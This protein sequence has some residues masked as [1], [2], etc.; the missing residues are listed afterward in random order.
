M[1]SVTLKPCNL[2][3][4]LDSYE[5]NSID[6][7][8]MCGVGRRLPVEAV[9]SPPSITNA[10]PSSS[11]VVR[12]GLYRFSN[13]TS[14]VVLVVSSDD[15]C[16]LAARF[17]C[18]R[19]VHYL[20]WSGESVKFYVAADDFSCH[21]L[22]SYDSD[23]ER[24]RALNQHC[25]DMMLAYFNS[26]P[27]LGF[28]ATPVALIYTNC[29]SESSRLKFCKMFPLDRSFLMRF[30]YFDEDWN[31]GEKV[32]RPNFTTVS[33][34]RQTLRSYRSCGSIICSIATSF[35]NNMMPAL[36][37][38]YTREPL[39]GK[40]D[41]SLLSFPPIFFTR[42][43]Q[44]EY[45]LEDRLGGD[46]DLTEPG[47][48]DAFDI[49]QFFK[50]QVASNS[51]LFAG[52]SEEW[53]RCFGFEVCCSQLRRTQ[54][55]AQPTADT[56]CSGKVRRL[57]C[58]NEIHA[59]ICEDMTNDEVKHFYPLIQSFR[60]MDKIGF[61]YP[62]GES[63]GDLVR[64]LTPF[65][66]DLTYSQKC[67]VVVAHQAVLRTVLSFFGGRPVEEAVHVPCPQRTIWVC[68]C[69]RLGEPRLAEVALAP[70]RQSNQAVTHSW[71]GW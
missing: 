40:P 68:T 5:R 39:H 41:D 30:I 33:M 56:L 53:D 49:A 2:L 57:K 45:N 55:T 26:N 51:N 3:D 7:R 6:F 8:D 27:K 37:Q 14:P 59:G 18:T 50:D 66:N 65:L 61:R 43:G 35:L 70:R 12:D 16:S 44:S 67:V 10:D 64:R 22:E 11:T 54:R 19:M 9:R 52:R 34:T 20:R 32:C 60:H 31:P 29:H 25:V 42:H 69:N 48:V 17:F 15:A 21:C 71:E 24:W 36:Y 1:V 47:R 13:A 23:P 28:L 46:P 62:E 4:E 58:L 63:Y 38:I